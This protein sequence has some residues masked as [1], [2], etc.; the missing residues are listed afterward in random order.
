M[1]TSHHVGCVRNAI[2]RD[3]IVF[4]VPLQGNWSPAEFIAAYQEQIK[5]ESEKVARSRV[6]H[7]RE[8][9]FSH[10]VALVNEANRY[11]EF[12]DHSARFTVPTD[13]D[14][15]KV[16]L[17]R[18]AAEQRAA[19]KQR[20]ARIASDNAERVA[21]WIAGDSVTLPWNLPETYLRIEGD[22][23]VT[24]KGARV[25]VAHA[26]TGLA[27]VRHIKRTGAEYVRNG[28]TVHLG[29]YAIDRID[30]DGNLTAGCHHI[31]FAEIERI[32][33]QL[34]CATVAGDRR[35]I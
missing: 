18:I 29:H 4:H 20:L 32:A 11:A 3:A 35:A 14:A 33:P 17:T 16:E 27:L 34:G 5:D 6:K 13:F 28:H 23:I 24:S 9:R 1:T 2:R 31:T 25:P 7:T 19:D 30:P 8:Y 26:I 15:L 21:Q 10:L 12:S 22:E